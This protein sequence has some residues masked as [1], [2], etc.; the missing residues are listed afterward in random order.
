VRPWIERQAISYEVYAADSKVVPEFAVRIFCDG[1]VIFNFN[2]SRNVAKTGM[3][4]AR[5]DE[6]SAR[7]LLAQAARLALQDFYDEI[8]A[9]RGKA[10][11]Q[12]GGSFSTSTSRATWPWE[13]ST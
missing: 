8:K 5:I 7:A 9:L 3:H 10:R 2:G 11:R 12:S 6:A 13:C 1:E 4:R